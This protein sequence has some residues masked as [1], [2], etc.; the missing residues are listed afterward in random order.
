M[1]ISNEKINE[2]LKAGEHFKINNSNEVFTIIQ[3]ANNIGEKI[4]NQYY[5]AVFLQ[6][7]G[8]Q[9]RGE[10]ESF[11]ENSITVSNY[12]ANYKSTLIIMH[13]QITFID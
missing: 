8:L 13:N 11:K 6:N 12:V 7:I 4:K 2:R 1:D 3:Y 9:Y 5:I 10:I